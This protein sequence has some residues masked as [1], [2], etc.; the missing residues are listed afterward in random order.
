MSVTEG[1]TPAAAVAAAARGWHVFPCKAGDN[2]PRDGWRW[3]QWHTTDPARVRQWWASGSDNVGI[4]AG[5]SSLV[6]IDLDTSKGGPLPPPWGN[7]PRDSRRHRRFR[8]VS[9]GPR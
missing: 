7:V 2:T 4:A 6:V 1:G 5:P 8:G 3:T 9:R